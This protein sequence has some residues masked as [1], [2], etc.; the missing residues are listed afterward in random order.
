MEELLAGSGGEVLGVERV[1][2][3]DNFF[4]LGRT[5]AAGDAGGVAGAGGAGSGGGAAARVRAPTV[6]ELAQQVEEARARSEVGWR[7]WSGGRRTRVRV[8]RCRMRS[9]GCGF[10]TSW[11]LGRAAYNMPQAV[12]LRGELDVGALERTLEEVVGRHEVLRTRFGEGGRCR[13]CSGWRGRLEVRMLRRDRRG[14]VRREELQRR[15][16]EGAGAGLI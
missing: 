11:R 10:S 4:E 16:R 7:R 8:C 14:G 13:R 9:S 5:L 12:R 3:T 2:W 6:A 1:G 15:V